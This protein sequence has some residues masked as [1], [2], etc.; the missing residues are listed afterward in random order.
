MSCD[1]NQE[2]V[3]TPGSYRCDCIQG[4]QRDA[5]NDCAGEY[6]GGGG[7]GRGGVGGDGRG[8]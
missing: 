3:N 6:L 1:F 7:G 2:C 5:E 4:T 8:G